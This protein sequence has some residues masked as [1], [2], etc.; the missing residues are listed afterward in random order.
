MSSPLDF[1]LSQFLS[2]AKTLASG[3]IPKCQC[4]SNAIPI[5]CICGQ[6]S[7][8]EHGFF[9]KN[10]KSICPS[11]AAELGFGEEEE[12]ED[13]EWFWDVLELNPTT[14]VK[15]IERA[16]KFQAQIKHP[17]KGGSQDEFNELQKAKEEAL[18]YARRSK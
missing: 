12:M 16:F 14:N 3:F 13:I 2:Q 15:Y 18:E 17:D 9:N 8:V 5:A 1:F 4:G 11:C 10:G 7:C 6:F